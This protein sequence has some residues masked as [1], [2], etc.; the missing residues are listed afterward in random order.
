MGFLSKVMQCS[1]IDSGDGCTTLEVLKT[2]VL[3]KWVDCTVCELHFNKTI[4]KK[5]PLLLVP[6]FHSNPVELFPRN[7]RISSHHRILAQ[8]V[9]SA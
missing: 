3:F 2:T 9:P 4:H 1:K 7:Q 5:S 6:L 8:A